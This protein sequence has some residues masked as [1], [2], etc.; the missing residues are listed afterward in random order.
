MNIKEILYNK[1]SYSREEIIFLLNLSDSVEI[2]KLFQ[3]AKEIRDSYFGKEIHLRGVIEFSN[4]CTQHCLYCGLREENLIIPRYRMS[5]EEILDTAK[6][7]YNNGIRT[8]VLQSGEDSFFDTDLISY[9]IYSIKRQYDVAITLSLGQRG[10]D[11]YKTWKIAGAD[12]Y[13][14][15][16]ESANPKLYS[17]YHKKAKLDERIQHLK[18][19]KR[20]GYQ[21]ASGNMI[22]LPNQTVA[23]IADDI[24]L[25]RE[26]DVDMAA[27]GPFIPSINTPYQNMP[28]GDTLMTQK[29]MA[30]V[31]LVLKNVHIP[32]TTALDSIDD[33]GREKGLSAGAN[34]IMPNFTP[35]PYRENYL[36]YTNKRG[37]NEDPLD[38][39]SQ[40]KSRIEAL[41][42]NISQSRGDSIKRS[43]S[44]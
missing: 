2:D 12:R 25:C 41:G 8:I 5:A 15:K 16:H 36:I 32:A 10:F 3:R 27:F 30:V 14:L 43:S 34:V 6:I 37:I 29:V 35:A 20:I 40:I 42:H 31:R 19:L 28:A 4:Y 17:I 18:F 1:D 11:E 26:L 21:I 33:F 44:I 22:G 23:D 9:L 24:L 38:I 13:L 7:I 39:H